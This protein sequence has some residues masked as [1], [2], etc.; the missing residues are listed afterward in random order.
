MM[1]MTFGGVSSKAH[2]D[3]TVLR[4]N[5]KSKLSKFNAVEH[6]PPHLEHV[7]LFVDDC[8]EVRALPSK[9]SP[10][11]LAAARENCCCVGNQCLDWH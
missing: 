10:P 9:S 4:L 1:C 2:L 8:C 3:T 11:K 7:A 5:K 6:N